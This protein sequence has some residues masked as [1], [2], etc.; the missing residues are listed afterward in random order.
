MNH[1]LSVAPMLDWTNRHCRYLHRLISPAAV[2]Y[3]EMVTTPAILQGD[4]KKYIGF[5]HSEHPVIL[6]LGGSDPQQLAQSSSIAA[7]YGYDGI[8]L[9]VG[10]PSDRVQKGRFGACLMNEPQLVVECIKAMQKATEIPISIKCRIGVDDNDSYENFHSFV[11]QMADAGIKTI[12]VHARKAW[13]KGLS[14]KQNRSV[15]PLNY[16]YV[17]KIKQQLPE[18]EIIIN[19]GIENIQQ[20]QY[21]LQNVDGVMLGRAIW[22]NPW[23]LYELQKALFKDDFSTSRDHVLNKYIAYAQQQIQ[24]GVKL[25]WL[26]PPILGLYHGLA[27]NK[28][29]KSHLV[30]QAP[31]RINDPLVFKE[32][33]E[34]IKL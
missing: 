33:R 23:L 24:K 22:N 3:T 29:W 31:T 15:P 32:A 19:G 12:I 11:Q 27:G 9:N 17:Y 5:N 10:C 16:D 1:R 21:H 26:L 2:L 34:L 25:H 8:N 6:Q 4:T 13:L 28:K 7:E 20:V 18:T 30:T 14:P